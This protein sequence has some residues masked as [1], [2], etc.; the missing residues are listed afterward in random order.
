MKVNFDQIYKKVIKPPFIL[1][2]KEKEVDE[3]EVSPVVYKASYHRFY[4]Y[5]Y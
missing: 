4:H 2:P 5:R 1:T 3:G